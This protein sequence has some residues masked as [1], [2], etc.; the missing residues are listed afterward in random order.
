M[1]YIHLM[2]IF[3]FEIIENPVRE[4]K[5]FDTW[6]FRDVLYERVLE[7]VARLEPRE[8]EDFFAM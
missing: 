5:G 8:Y 1:S 4:Y 7:L 2:F 6:S 3:L